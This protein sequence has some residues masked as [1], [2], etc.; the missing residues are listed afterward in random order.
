MQQHCT[1]DQSSIRTLSETRN[2]P[3][4]RFSRDVWLFYEGASHSVIT[5]I[6]QKTMSITSS[7]WN[8][9]FLTFESLP[10]VL[11]MES[12]PPN[13]Y[14]YMLSAQSDYIRLRLLEKFGGWWMD[15]TTLVNDITWM[16]E[17]YRDVVENDAIFAGFCYVQCPFKL[18]ESSVLY[19]PRGSSF[20]KLWREELEKA[21]A[22]GVENYIYSIYRQGFDLP[23]NQFIR[24]PSVGRYFVVYATQQYV[25]HYLLPRNRSLLVY[26][27]E[28][29]IYK[30]LHDCQYRTDCISE[31]LRMELIQP[32]YNVTKIWSSQR[33]I[34]WPGSAANQTE[35]VNRLPALQ[36]GLHLSDEIVSFS[37]LWIFFNICTYNFLY[38]ISIIMFNNLVHMYVPHGEQLL[39][40]YLS[41]IS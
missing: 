21:F 20:I 26:K 17:V 27:A 10:D 12:F 8:P 28:E 13:F 40:K 19:S 36:V 5:T 3:G 4:D 32:R 25:L 15:A 9:H 18:I 16:E 29:V 1:F 11:E 14:D 35:H 37:L 2:I 34:T 39:V 24:Y 6:I 7:A 31:K 38:V 22:V 41:K 23:Q 33:N 30:L